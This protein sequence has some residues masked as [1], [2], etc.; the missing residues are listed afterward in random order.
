MAFF[1][2]D[3]P[4]FQEAEELLCI[5]E[6]KQR[7]KF[8]IGIAQN[9]MQL[10]S[11]YEMNKRKRKR[12]DDDFDYIYGVVTTAQEWHFLLYTPGSISKGRKIP[13]TVQF[14]DDALNKNSEDYRIL[15]EEVKKILEIIVG[16]IKDRVSCV[17]EEPYRKKSR[18]ESRIIT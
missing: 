13:Y 17:G 1:T 12:V 7:D 2:N 14:T 5:T 16:L 15:C 8:N 4:S 6:N 10:E 3:T 11:A 18:I 9:I